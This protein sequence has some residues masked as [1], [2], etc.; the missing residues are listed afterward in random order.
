[1][2]EADG[3]KPEPQGRNVVQ[4]S[5]RAAKPEKPLLAPQDTEETTDV[6]FQNST[7]TLLAAKFV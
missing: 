5:E 1:M 4:S 3:R 2:I 6:A 7:V